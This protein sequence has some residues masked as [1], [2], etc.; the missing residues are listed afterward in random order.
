MVKVYVTYE[1][2]KDFHR[3]WYFTGYT[4]DALDTS[5]GYIEV[6]VPRNAV[7]D[8]SKRCGMGFCVAVRSRKEWDMK[9]TE[10][11]V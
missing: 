1:D 8:V 5:G 6:I 3:G 2:F 9:P 10:Y 7:L 4:K 11:I